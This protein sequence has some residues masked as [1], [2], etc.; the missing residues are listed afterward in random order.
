MD[1]ARER[2]SLLGFCLL[3]FVLSV[4]F[5]GI[6]VLANAGVIPDFVM[7]R[8]AW[9]LTPMMAASILVYRES[10]AVGVKALFNALLTC[11]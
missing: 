8:A 2:R 3:E 1:P 6:S 9:S 7:F 10:K 5:W 11:T 4:P